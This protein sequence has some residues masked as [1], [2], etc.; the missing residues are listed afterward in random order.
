MPEI[1]APKRAENIPHEDA[2]RAHLLLE[3]RLSENT[4]RSY[5]SD[6]RLCLWQLGV[7]GKSGE[8]LAGLET[9]A[10]RAFLASLAELGFSP[11][12]LARYLA[13]LKSYTAYL[14]DAN[15]L[16]VDFCRGVRVPKQQRYKPRS[17]SLKEIRELYEAAERCVAAGGKG[18]R[19]DLVLLELLY[20]LGLRVS[21]AI[22]L[23]IDSLRF[24]EG[25]AMVQGKGKKQRVVPMGKKVVAT[26]QE[27]LA[28][29]RPGLAAPRC[30]T[31][32]VNLRGLSLSRMGAW[33][34]ARKLC[35]AAGLN[36]EGISPHTFRHTFATHLIEAGADLRAVQELLG[37]ADIGTTQI[38]THL[39]QDYLRE[40][41]QSFHPRN[42]K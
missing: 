5:L 32:L 37:H 29:E 8:A 20:G 36:P 6:L 21:E 1:I 17:L 4:A 41:H 13:S 27:Y 2:Y 10:T 18:A 11:S 28:A 31:L 3:K 12:T 7:A 25:L 42:Q 16:T 19:R 14:L 15:L 34:I 40:T 22:K 24:D 35:L 23:P 39:D 38:Y 9:E 26:L 33:N 30:G